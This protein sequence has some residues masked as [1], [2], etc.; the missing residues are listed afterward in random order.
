MPRSALAV[1]SASTP[2]PSSSARRSTR[3]SSS[4]VGRT[5]LSPSSTLSA[6]HHPQT[7]DELAAEEAAR[8]LHLADGPSKA[9]RSRG[10]ARQ[11]PRDLR[12]RH[13]N[14]AR[15][16]LSPLAGR[17]RK[18]SED[19]GGDDEEDGE[20]AQASAILGGIVPSDEEDEDDSSP[21]PTAG[22]LEPLVR[23]TPA[24]TRQ[25]I[26]V[27]SQ[28]PQTAEHERPAPVAEESESNVESADSSSSSSEDDSDSDTSTES[29]TTSD[30]EADSD[31][32]HL[33]ALLEKAKLSAQ[34]KLSSK[35]AEAAQTTANGNGEVLLSFDD[36]E[37]SKER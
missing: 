11:S 36:E 21:P 29:D 30:S 15:E 34:A 33:E 23:R 7:A 13:L 9:L 32:G 14:E 3:V 17:D 22:R 5:P 4:R 1:S 10:S 2:Q 35:G 12:H 31:D 27:P 25:S 6:A 16:V 8:L 19:G 24:A 26:I 20:I 28:E 18:T 37:S